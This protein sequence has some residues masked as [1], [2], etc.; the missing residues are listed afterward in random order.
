MCRINC[1]KNLVG[2]DVWVACSGGVDSIVAAHYLFN[3]LKRNVKLF[4][5]NHAL[6]AQNWEMEKAVKRFAAYYN[7]PIEIRRAH[8]DPNE[9]VKSPGENA[10]RAKRMRALVQVVGDGDIIYGH[11][12]N[13]CV[14]SY[15]MN[16]FNGVGEYCP[17]PI[18]RGF[19]SATVYR[20]FMLTPKKAFERYADAYNLRDFIVDDETNA[21]T[22]YRR[23]WVR[24]R[25]LP[26]IEEEYPGLEKVVFKKMVK[27]YEDH[28]A[29]D[30]I[31]ELD[32]DRAEEF[33]RNKDEN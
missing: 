33:L 11:H 12:L 24:N 25:L 23:N 16:T 13:D 22:K 2:N 17:I 10:L 27:F 15:L 28:Y 29:Q 32:V 30:W 20:P 18:I 9:L 19:D 4:H 8:W 3:K 6:R 31:E 7:L 26:V 21:N 5:F 14:E 1:Q